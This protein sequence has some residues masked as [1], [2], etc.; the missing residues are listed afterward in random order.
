MSG[1]TTGW[2]GT[3]PSLPA[4]INTGSGCMGKIAALQCDD[5]LDI[6][7]DETGSSNPLVSCLMSPKVGRS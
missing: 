3:E 7:S 5:K 4:L 6:Q 2:F 1:T